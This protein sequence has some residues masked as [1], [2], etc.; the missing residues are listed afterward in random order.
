MGYFFRKTI[1]VRN[2]FSLRIVYIAIHFSASAINEQGYYY[3][4]GVVVVRPEDKKFPVIL[5]HV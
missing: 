4:E 5:D 3:I 1:R 2:E